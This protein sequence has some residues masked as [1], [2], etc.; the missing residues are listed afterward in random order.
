MA[1]EQKVGTNVGTDV[2]CNTKLTETSG[3]EINLAKELS[4][5]EKERDYAMQCEYIEDLK[6]ANNMIYSIKIK[7][8]LIKP[9]E[10]V[11][12]DNSE[13]KKKKV[14]I[15][16]AKSEDSE[17]DSLEEVEIKAEAPK[18]QKVKKYRGWMLTINNP[19]EE[20]EE[21]LKEDKYKYLVY[22]IEKGEEEETE[23]IQAF[24]YYENPRIWPKKR[25]PTAHIEVSRCI[26]ASIKYCQKEDTRVRG[27]YEFGTK[28]EQGRRTDLEELA[29]EI[30]EGKKKPE[31]F[32]KINPMAYVRYHKGLQALSE[33]NKKHRDMNVKAKVIWLWGKAQGGKSY[34]IYQN[35]PGLSVY[36]KDA[37]K[38]WN[39]YEQE[40]IILIDDFETQTW[41][42]RDF[43]RLLDRYPYQAQNKG[44][45]LK[46]NSKYIVITC[47]YPP[48][49]LWEAG[50]KLDQVIRRIDEVI[51]LQREGGRGVKKPIRKKI[52]VAKDYSYKSEVIVHPGGEED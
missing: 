12:V 16:I 36:P 34:W 47:E 37:T 17:E 9:K 15:K 31:D 33:L 2:S 29:K 32:A 50:N 1:T 30:M 11:K 44:G 45:Y 41:G 51:E 10:K 4:Y 49:E 39:N 6:H 40:D 8:G 7:M 38:W 43:L 28:P 14:K 18:D 20:D 3:S 23:H 5:W 22:Q 24:L 27:P 48:E 21:I 46:I 25:Y 13:K 26:T 52:V 19:T 42:Y 35:L